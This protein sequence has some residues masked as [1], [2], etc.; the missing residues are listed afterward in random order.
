MK[1]LD[2]QTALQKGELELK[3]QFMFGSNYTFLVH[4]RY[5]GREIPAVYKPLRGEQPLWD[6]PDNTLSR[7]EVAAYLVSEALGFHFIPYTTLRDDGPFYG[8]GSLQ[9]YIESD[10]EYHYFSFSDTDKQRLRPVVLFDILA[11]NADRK[12]SHILIEKGTNK[13][14][15]IDHGLCFHYEE[16]LRTVL[17]DFAGEPIPGD[18]LGCLNSF[19]GLLATNSEFR[20]SLKPYLSAREISALASR[21]KALLGTKRFPAPPRDRRAYPYPPI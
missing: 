4:V 1:Q 15:A 10:P 6:F 5:D 20:V 16:K 13:V 17:W 2:L 3:G 9:Q 7:R 11:N 14:W 8:P 19:P 18:L 21:A 12:G